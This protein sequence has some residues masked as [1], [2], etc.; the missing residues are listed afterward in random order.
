MAREDVNTT[1]ELPLSTATHP[2]GNRE[3]HNT[4]IKE[5][6]ILPLPPHIQDEKKFEMEVYARFMSYL[7]HVP[8]NH[9]E[10]KILSAI[11]FTADTVDVGEALVAKTLVDLGLYAPRKAFPLSFLHFVDKSLRRKIWRGDHT[12][13]S[14]VGLREHWDEIGEAP[15][16]TALEAPEQ[17]GYNTTVYAGRS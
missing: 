11:R 10:I 8:N 15:L 17:G 3:P 4:H 5:A 9:M 16:T 12:P 13:T 2:T 1:G 7:R 14:I 6:V